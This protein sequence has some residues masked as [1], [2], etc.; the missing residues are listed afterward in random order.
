MSPYGQR[1]ALWGTQQSKSSAGT[2][3]GS[4]DE[5]QAEGVHL[6]GEEAAPANEGAARLL[7]V[8]AVPCHSPSITRVS[9][10]ALPAGPA[11]QSWPHLEAAVHFHL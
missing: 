10:R 9:P 3:R 2:E 8:P 6:L 7:Q 11:L 1:T 4:C 5:V